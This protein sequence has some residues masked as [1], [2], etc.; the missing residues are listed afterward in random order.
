MRLH[1]IHSS[2]SIK[3]NVDSI[4]VH[5]D[6]SWMNTS[7]SDEKIG[8]NCSI[9]HIYTELALKHVIYGIKSKITE[10]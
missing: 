4:K 5:H 9:H 6:D 8:R 10:L 2:E 7:G 1:A 3:E